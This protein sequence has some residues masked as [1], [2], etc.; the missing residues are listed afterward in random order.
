ML[1][2][3]WYVAAEAYYMH[4]GFTDRQKISDTYNFW[5]GYAGRLLRASSLAVGSAL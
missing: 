5:G 4:I 2:N 1:K 3:R